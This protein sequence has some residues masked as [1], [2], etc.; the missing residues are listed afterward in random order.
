[1]DD[2]IR[3][4]MTFLRVERSASPETLRSYTSDLRQFRSFLLSH[5]LAGPSIDPVS[6]SAEA[7]R[8]YLQWL[9]R[10]GGKRS[11]LA[12]KL[13]SIR[14]FYRF[15][16]RDGLVARNPAEDIRTP[17]QTKPLPRVLTKEEADALMTV[18]NNRTAGSL[19][20][21]ALLETLYSTGAR[22]SELV[23]LDLDDLRQSDGIVRLLGKGK[24]ERMVPIGD[25]AIRAIGEY[26][27]RHPIGSRPAGSPKGYRLPLFRNSR[28]GRLTTRSVARIVAGHSSGLAG[29]SIS[30]HTL[31]HSFA[32][33]LLDEGADLRAI[34]EML[35]HA[36]LGT[37]QKYTHVAMDQLLALYDK[38]HPRAG[39]AA[40]ARGGKNAKP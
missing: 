32:T 22:V 33:H 28:G 15:L 29:G 21:R 4:F 1:M 8:G 10:R 14:S 40:H 12:R 9:D 35:G 5:R 37:T 20:D 24:K 2:A 7:I 19:R 31:R 36:S 26:L 3:A 11:S 13:A 18:P 17:K 25:V 16:T 23:A 34:Q 39:P 30:P 6:I 38:A 27:S